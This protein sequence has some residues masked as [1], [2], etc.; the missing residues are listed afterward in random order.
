M[1]RANEIFID[2]CKPVNLAKFAGNGCVIEEQNERAL[3][4][5]TVDL[6]K[7]KLMPT[8]SHWQRNVTGE[9]NLRNMEEANYIL[10][11]FNFFQ[12]FWEYQHIIPE[13]W[14]E[15][16]KSRNR[17]IYFPGSVIKLADDSRC[18]LGMLFYCGRWSHTKRKLTDYWYEDHCS[19][20][21]EV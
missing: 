8:F 10:L 3:A 11:G 5:T 18:I 1:E 16:V 17:H 14:K 6:A 4:F 21:L 12:Y 9:E 7:I 13:T 19:A 2:H 15:K 20:V